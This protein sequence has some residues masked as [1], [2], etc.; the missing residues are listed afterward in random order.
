[1]EAKIRQY[2]LPPLSDRERD[3]ILSYL[4]RNASH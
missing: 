4:T 2:R 1:M 3:T